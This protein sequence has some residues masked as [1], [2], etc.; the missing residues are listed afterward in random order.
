ML[1]KMDGDSSLQQ[2]KCDIVFSV[3][4]S[5]DQAVISEKRSYI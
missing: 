1:Q 4:L 5:L 3:F 2:I